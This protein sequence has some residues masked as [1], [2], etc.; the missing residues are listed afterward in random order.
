[1]RRG[2]H[3]SEASAH[4]VGINVSNNFQDLL[5]LLYTSIVMS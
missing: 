1:M 5:L 2:D 3:N 4:V